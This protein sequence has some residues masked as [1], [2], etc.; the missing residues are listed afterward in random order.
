[1][2]RMPDGEGP[3][4]TASPRLGT[5]SPLEAAIDR[6]LRLDSLDEATKGRL[7]R[8]SDDIARVREESREDLWGKRPPALPWSAPHS[9]MRTSDIRPRS[10]GEVMRPSLR[11]IRPAL[12]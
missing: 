4:E 11:L 3:P 1:M 2:R 9:S 12:H 6:M 10:T 7:Q 8:I 5:A